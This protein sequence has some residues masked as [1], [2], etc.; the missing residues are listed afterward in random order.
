VFPRA[1]IRVSRFV[2]LGTPIILPMYEQVLVRPSTI[3]IQQENERESIMALP[4]DSLLTG[5]AE[6][7]P[8]LLKF[9]RR[10][11]NC[12]PPTLLRTI[13]AWFCVC[14]ISNGRLAQPL[15]MPNRWSRKFNPSEWFLNLFRWSIVDDGLHANPLIVYLPASYIYF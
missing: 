15:E 6:Y 5:Y 13:A 1:E 14:Y 4:L 10:C 11:S 2:V 8:H 12:T 7:I 3:I 9:T